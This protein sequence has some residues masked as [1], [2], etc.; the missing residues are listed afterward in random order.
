MVAYCVARQC[1][2]NYQFSQLRNITGS[3]RRLDIPFPW[4]SVK[5]FTSVRTYVRHSRVRSFSR[6]LFSFI[7]AYSSSCSRNDQ[8]SANQTIHDRHTT[9]PSKR[10]E[11]GMPCWV[12]RIVPNQ[13][14]Q[15]THTSFHVKSEMVTETTKQWQWSTKVLR[16]PIQ[17][18]EKWRWKIFPC[19]ARVGS[20]LRSSRHCLWHW[21]YHSKTPHAAPVLATIVS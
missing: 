2:K 9:F 19:F 14:F 20:V 3:K 17:T 12:V 11:A 18:T 13:A 8:E 6:Q 5:L 16:E 15:P 1:G 4:Q 10:R 21:L 7:M